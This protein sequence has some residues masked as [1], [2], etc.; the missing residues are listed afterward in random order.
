M[1]VNER[2]TIVIPRDVHARIEQLHELTAK[3]S[4]SEPYWFT[5]DR[6]IAALEADI[7]E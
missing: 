4:G 1:S 7:D 6:A 3:D 2:T 5:I